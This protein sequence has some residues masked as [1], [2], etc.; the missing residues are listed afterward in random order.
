VGANGNPQKSAAA[1]ALAVVCFLTYLLS[2]LAEQGLLGLSN[3][4][5]GNPGKLSLIA[6]LVLAILFMMT[7]TNSM[8]NSDSPFIHNGTARTGYTQLELTAIKTL[9]DM[10]AGCPQNRYVLRLYLPLYNRL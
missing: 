10:E 8:G 9:P 7:T 6:V 4:I 3:L 5:R 1:L 2:I